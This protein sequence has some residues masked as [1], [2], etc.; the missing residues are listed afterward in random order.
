MLSVHLFFLMPGGSKLPSPDTA[1][2]KEYVTSILLAAVLEYGTR[3]L[4]AA[5]LEG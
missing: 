1:A 5:V 4:L 2:R 3:I